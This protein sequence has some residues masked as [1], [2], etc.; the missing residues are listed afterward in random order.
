MNGRFLRGRLIIHFFFQIAFAVGK[1][2]IEQSTVSLGIF[3]AGCC[4]GGGGSNM[5]SYLLKGDLS[6]SITMTTIS[7]VAALGEYI[8]RMC[9]QI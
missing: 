1:L 5:Y 7:T 2:V 6:L 4:P 3:V 8:I 9:F